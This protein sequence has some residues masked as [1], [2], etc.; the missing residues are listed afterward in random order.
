MYFDPCQC[1][2]GL[3]LWFYLT[4]SSENPDPNNVTF[5]PPFFEPADGFIE[6][7]CARLA[8]AA[9]V[10]ETLTDLRPKEYRINNTLS[11]TNNFFLLLFFS[12]Y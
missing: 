11:S 4:L 5:V 3:L 2:H 9:L 12:V 6:V 8:S 1:M 10:T 7:T